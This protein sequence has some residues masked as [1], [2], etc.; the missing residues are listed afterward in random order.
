MWSPKSS[1]N[2]SRILTKRATMLFNRVKDVDASLIEVGHKL[3]TEL[4]NIFHIQAASSSAGRL[5]EHNGQR[6]VD[7]VLDL[8]KD[9]PPSR[10]EDLPPSPFSLRRLRELPSSSLS[11]SL[12]STPRLASDRASLASTDSLTLE[13]PCENDC[14]FDLNEEQEDDKEVL[15]D[16]FHVSSASSTSEEAER[17]GLRD[18]SARAAFGLTPRRPCEVKMRR[19]RSKSGEE[20]FVGAMKRSSQGC[21]RGVDL[22][23]LRSLSVLRVCDLIQH[24]RAHPLRL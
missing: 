5:V 21:G 18:A 20:I 2:S 16:P 17:T 3:A 10:L 13:P 11:T 7:L 23:P 19:L 15:D 4:H 22:P 1:P 12:Q 8:G 14:C 6:R 9:S 24:S